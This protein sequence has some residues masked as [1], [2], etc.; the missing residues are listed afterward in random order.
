MTSPLDYPKVPPWKLREL[1]A[2]EKES[3]GFYVSGHPLDEFGADLSRLGVLPTSCLVRLEPWSRVRVGGMVED[4]REKTFK[5]GSGK[6]AFFLLEDHVGRVEVKVRQ[7]RIEPCAAALTSKEPVLLSG[8][9]S[10]PQQQQ[11]KPEDDDEAPGAEGRA[12]DAAAGPGGHGEPMIVLDEAMLLADALRDEPRFLGIRVREDRLD[13]KRISHV[14]E[15]LQQ[16]PGRCRVQLVLRTKAG[17]DVVLALG[18]EILVEPSP[19]LLGQLE[20][21]L[22]AGAQK[23]AELPKRAQIVVAGEPTEPTGKPAARGE[24]R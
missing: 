3:I 10:M 13:A 20:D 6:V 22:G 14:K 19:R 17:A 8:R 18:R 2:R 11:E 12:Q 23:E 24:V 4:Y 21:I 9:I 5:D 15:A 1:L 7:Q 16:N